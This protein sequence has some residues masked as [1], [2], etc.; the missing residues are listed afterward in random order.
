MRW[1]RETRTRSTCP[2]SEEICVVSV[3]VVRNVCESCG[4]VRFSYETGL[5]GEVERSMF[6]RPA[7]ELH[8]TIELP[9]TPWVPEQVAAVA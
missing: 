3:G 6:A 4:Q 7:D 5:S 2:H 8:E 1:N 9:V